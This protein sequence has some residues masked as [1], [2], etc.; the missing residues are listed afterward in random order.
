MPSS[1][2]VPVKAFNY[3][4]VYILLI[5]ATILTD[6]SLHW[7][8]VL[9]IGRYFGIIGTLL[10]ILSMNYSLRKRKIITSGGVKKY[11]QFHEYTSWIGSFLILVHAGIHFNALLPWL[12]IIAMLINVGSG[13]TGKY[14]HAK[15][16]AMLRLKRNELVEIGHSEDEVTS[17][18]FLDSL[19]V[20]IIKKWRVVHIPITLVFTLLAVAHIIIV[21]MYMGRF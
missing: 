2:S 8:N 19:S 12:A 4:L 9:W 20:D 13:L 10:I 15:S 14:L 17:R 21:L 18:I 7:M 16:I 3:F 1:S 11:L 6:L 5:I